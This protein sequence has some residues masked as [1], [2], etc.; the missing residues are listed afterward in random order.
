MKKTGQ[1]ISLPTATLRFD[2]PFS[3]VHEV[4][5]EIVRKSLHFLIALGPSLASFNLVFTMILLSLGTTFS[6]VAEALRL[7]GKEIFIVSKLTKSAARTRDAGRFV[8]GPVTLGLGAL[9]ALTFY[10]NPAAA[11]AIYALAF[12]DGFASLI[13]K[14]FGTVRIPFTGGKS[15]EGS[16]ACFLAVFIATYLCT[17]SLS[18]S[19]LIAVAATII[20]AAPLKDF[21]NIALPCIIGYLSV[22][23]FL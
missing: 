14:V 8:L 16:L 10:P 1:A 3:A 4:K 23:L 18:G 6:A 19:F 17:S 20:E 12:G 22:I 2:R 15:L 7:S 21:D 9:L 5:T 13:G 11:V